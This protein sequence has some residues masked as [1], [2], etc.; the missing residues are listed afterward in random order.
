MSRTVASHSAGD[1]TDTRHQPVLRRSYSQWTMRISP[2]NGYAGGVK[3]S[4]GASPALRRSFRKKPTARDGAAAAWRLPPSHVCTPSFSASAFRSSSFFRSFSSRSSSSIAFRCTIFTR[5]SMS[6]RHSS[7][8]ALEALPFSA[9]V[10]RAFIFAAPPRLRDEALA[11]QLEHLLLV[12]QDLVARLD[13]GLP[14]GDLRLAGP[15]LL[16]LLEDVDRLL[17]EEKN[18]I[19]F[20]YI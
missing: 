20:F 19:F 14:F 16:L 13:G 18:L 1:A 9:S 17:L 8:S 2:A 12:P 3:G 4:G 7:I 6:R 15:E 11:L 10:S 5:L